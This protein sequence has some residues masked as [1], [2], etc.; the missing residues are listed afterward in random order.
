MKDF[1]TIGCCGIDCALC[2]RYHTK[3]SSKCPGCFGPGFS[4][5]HPGCS[6]ITCCV[7]RRGLETCAQCEAFPCEKFGGFDSADSFVTHKMCLKNL[8]TIRE[9]GLSEFLKSQEKRIQLLERMLE[10]YDDGRSKGFYCLSAALLPM[11]DLERAIGQASSD[12]GVTDKKKRQ[13]C[14]EGPCR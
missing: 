11:E 3:G 10:E 9:M 2:P 14:C 5:K 4:D 12:H 7:K 13:S 6:I 1:P 8:G